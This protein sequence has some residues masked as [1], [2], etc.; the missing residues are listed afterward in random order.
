M[1]P[2][3]A[4]MQDRSGKR[5]VNEQRWAGK[6]DRRERGTVL[7]HGVVGKVALSGWR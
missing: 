3:P 6:F 7:L 5:N 2:F 4:A 1:R